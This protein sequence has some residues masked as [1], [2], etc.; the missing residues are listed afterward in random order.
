MSR[1]GSN[2]FKR[3][4]G[5]WEGRY[6]SG[7]KENS[8]AKYTSVYAHSYTECADKLKKSIQNVSLTES[9]MTVS[10]LFNA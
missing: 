4:D 9:A 7:I 8:H 2:I 3:K 6:K 1:R 10:D 5:H